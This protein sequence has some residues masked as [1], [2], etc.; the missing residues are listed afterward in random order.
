M[1]WTRMHGLSLELWGAVCAELG[2]RL[3]DES[4]A[5]R[6]AKLKFIG[7][8]QARPE[9]ARL[10]VQARLDALLGRLTGGLARAAGHRTGS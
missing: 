4:L 9:P 5:L 10:Q 3:G 6:G 7:A 2:G 8:V 1:S